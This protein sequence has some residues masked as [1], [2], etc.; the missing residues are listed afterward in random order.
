M[1]V[2]AGPATPG[3]C[4]SAAIAPFGMT[5]REAFKGSVQQV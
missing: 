1:K 5:I 3:A 2:G 4:G